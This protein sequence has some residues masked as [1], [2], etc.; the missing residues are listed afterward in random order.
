MGKNKG[1]RQGVLRSVNTKRYEAWLQDPGK[2]MGWIG[3]F[4]LE[5]LLDKS[6]GLAKISNFL[7]DYVAEGVLEVLKQ[8]PAKHWNVTEAERNPADNNIAHKFW[9]S[10]TAPGLEAIVRAISVLQ[11][12]RI[13]TFSAGKYEKS[14]HIEPHDD[15]AY[16]DVVV[17][18]CASP[19]GPSFSAEP[20]VCQKKWRLKAAGA[21]VKGRGSYVAEGSAQTHCAAL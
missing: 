20:N 19:R 3:K 1:G 6:G 18:V 13:N 4:N 16:A 17:E 21:I 2:V 12:G 14:N 10:K 7:P 15:R 5:K 8:V 11:P 9:S